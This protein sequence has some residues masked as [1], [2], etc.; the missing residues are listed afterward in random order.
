MNRVKRLLAV[1]AVIALLGVMVFP[2][3]SITAQQNG[4]LSNIPVTA[5]GGFSGLLNITSLT[6]NSAGQLVASGTLVY[7]NAGQTVTQAFSGIVASLIGGSGGTCSILTLDLGPIHLDLLGLTV[8][9]AAV[10]LNVNAV[11]GPGQLLGNLLCS[12]A[13]L[14]DNNGP[15]AGLTN[16]LNQVNRLL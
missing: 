15:L 12:V 5:P 6:L 10:H 2:A 3:S 1:I 4:L 16:L 13:H 14:L 7:Q 8:D 11:S 9:L